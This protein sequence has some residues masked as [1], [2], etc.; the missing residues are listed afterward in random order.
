VRPSSLLPR[1]LLKSD[2]DRLSF[3]FNVMIVGA[4]IERKAYDEAM[5]TKPN[6][7]F[8]SSRAEAQSLARRA[9]QALIEMK[10]NG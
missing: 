1:G 10:E 3:D 5:R 8:T 7:R 2:L 4:H 6:S 9:E